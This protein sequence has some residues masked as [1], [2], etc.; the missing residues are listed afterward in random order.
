MHNFARTHRTHY[1]PD[2]RKCI[3]TGPICRSVCRA[4]SGGAVY[5]SDKPGE[6]DFDLLR[7]LVLPD[8]SVLRACGAARPSR[9]CLFV[10][11]LR[12]NKSL[13]KV[14]NTNAVTRVA[15]VFHLQGSSWDRTRRKYYIHDTKP[16]RLSATV[17]P[18]DCEVHAGHAHVGS[19]ALRPAEPEQ[20]AMYMHRLCALSVVGPH[21]GVGVSLRSGEA[22]AVVVSAVLALGPVRF[23]PIGLCD[24]Y[25]GGG[26]V[27][28]VVAAGSDATTVVVSLRGCG[29]FLAY[30]SAPPLRVACD[31]LALAFDYDMATGALHID[32]PHTG[33]LRAELS[34]SF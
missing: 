13:L 25:N 33:D 7:R 4:I 10:D 3:G 15:G 11:V 31:R 18:V 12:D 34:I 23:A 30:S 28:A 29:R 22:E 9:D 24:M 5:V 20:Y 14:W 16:A 17:R 6:H 8:G 19:G 21:D 26:A 2:R 1:C 32:A 27:V